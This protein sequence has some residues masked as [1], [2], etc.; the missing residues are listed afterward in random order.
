M[1]R[2]TF[3]S[4]IANFNR[5]CSSLYTCDYRQLALQTAAGRI[6]QKDGEFTGTNAR[7]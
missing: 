6:R 1:T 2:I 3:E 7:G 5:V 4:K